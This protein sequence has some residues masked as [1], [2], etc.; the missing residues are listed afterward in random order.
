MRIKINILSAL[1][2]LILHNHVNLQRSTTIKLKEIK[3]RG[4]NLI[5]KKTLRNIKIKTRIQTN[6]NL[7]VMV[8]EIKMTPPQTIIQ[9]KR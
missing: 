6:W 4:E 8:M 7:I 9:A 3:N 1:V 2:L 5:S